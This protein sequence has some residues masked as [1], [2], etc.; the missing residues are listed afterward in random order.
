MDRGAPACAR[1][2]PAVGSQR[3]RTDGDRG[4]EF[5]SASDP[6]HPA[7][8]ALGPPKAPRLLGR[9]NELATIEAKI[10]N[11]GTQGSALVLRG[12]PGVGK[13]AL[14]QAAAARAASRGV[15]VLTAVGVESEADI[16]FSGLHQLMLPVLGGYSAHGDEF[17]P[18]AAPDDA[19]A[20]RL[21]RL[22]EPQREALSTIFGLS[23]GAAPDRLLVGLAVL[24]LL[25]EVAAERP[26]A[27]LI[28]DVQWVDR[29][30]AQ[31]LAFVARRLF[32]EPVF[33]LFATRELSEETRGLPEVV[34]GGLD[35]HDAA[36]LLSSVVS[37][38]IDER[39]AERIIAET[40][41]IP[42]ALLEVPR[43]LSPEQLAGGFGVPVEPGFPESI[44]EVFR[45]RLEGLSEEM[46]LLL[47][48]AAAEP[49]G[50][51][52]LVRLAAHRLGITDETTAEALDVVSANGLL[53]VS[54]RV[55]FR[56]PVIR[57]AVYNG[58]SS[59]ERRRVH[60]ALA[61]VIDPETDRERRAW[62]KAHATVHA[63]EEV[64]AE[65]E[66]CAT[67]AQG[68]GGLAAAAAF[69]ERAAALTPDGEGRAR[70]ALEAAY[71][72]YQAGS[73]E[74]ALALVSDA[75]RGRLDELGRARADLLRGQIA[76]ASAGGHAAAQLLLR[77]AQR[78]ETIDAR[79]ARDTYL[80][81]LSAA[82][83]GGAQAGSTSARTV[84][85]AA[86]KA[87]LVSSPPR[88]TDL[89]LDGLAARFSDGLI[90]AIPALQLAIRSFRGERVDREE[91]LRWLWL[92]CRTAGQIWDSDS[93]DVLSARHVRLA[94][95]AGA[96]SVLPLALSMRM[97]ALAFLEGP[98]AAASLAGELEAISGAM[99]VGGR[100]YGTLL[101]AAW[102]GREREDK[103][104][105][106]SIAA[107]FEDREE[108]IGIVAAHWAGAVLGN[109]LGRYEEAYA[110]A[111]TATEHPEDIPFSSWSLIELIISSVRTGRLDQAAKAHATQTEMTSACGTEWAR[112]TEALSQALLSDGSEAEKLYREAITRFGR[113]RVRVWLARSHLLYGEWA[114][115]ERRRVHA[116]RQLRTA[117]EMFA[118][119][120]ATAFAD[121]AVRELAATG[122]H[123]RPRVPGARDD[124]T[125][126]ESQ[127]ARL[128]GQG[129]SNP[130][131]GARLFI[132]PRTVEYHLHKVFAKL[133]ISSRSQLQR[134]G[135]ATAID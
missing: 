72:M 52:A 51:P 99:G 64:A 43:T 24:S 68:R 66:R 38:P 94:R 1:I 115:R 4:P 20:A 37:G 41:G 14:L 65:L 111:T 70:R 84:A 119:M 46:R 79:L 130:E 69:L 17:S 40:R 87:G 31:T 126:R 90:P 45:L 108:G 47:L 98:L 36:R 26:V 48:V 11:L 28:D 117:R 13:T 76:F 3:P 89:L 80:E 100:S 133:E 9:E 12:E 55:R 120:G 116:R 127:V 106:D 33:L 61:E 128:A 129:L 123:A 105:I 53:E 78:L 122:E 135:A 104:L 63:D 23:V 10:E 101:V 113:A 85:L 77:A 62:H 29:A 86:R 74:A 42:L 21:E 56:H 132:S 44:E 30:S 82:E 71:A 57:T 81:A 96:L 58:A 22:P 27:G 93:W 118:A 73:P 92:A 102:S 88:P 39:V 114:R 50:D 134:S 6:R 49:T 8:G 60:A 131:I 121:R 67:T 2:W 97:T 103:E 18:A 5:V 110:A 35:P 7:S 91:E 109:G 107:D 124:L 75:E 95:D 19:S 59:A 15:L 112:A 83:F 125:P 25:S 34:V 32:A 54:R 16:T